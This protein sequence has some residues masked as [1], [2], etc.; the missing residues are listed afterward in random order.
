MEQ[1]L[2]E[3][4]FTKVKTSVFEGAN[5]ATAGRSNEEPGV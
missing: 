3:L 4:G 5:H 2:K 1:A